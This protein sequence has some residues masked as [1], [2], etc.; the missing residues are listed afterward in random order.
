MH[1]STT[2][3][4]N[5]L[6]FLKG[7]AQRR[8]VVVTIGTKGLTDA[9]HQELDAA[10][11]HHELLKLRIPVLSKTDNQQL[12]EDLCHHHHVVLIQQLGRVV[13]IYRPSDKPHITLP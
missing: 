6:Q 10:L 7:L 13:S 3:N 11:Q 8:K 2:L 1:D 9:L 5:Q 12:L 4:S